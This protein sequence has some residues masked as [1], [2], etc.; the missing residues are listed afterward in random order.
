MVK[1]L[2]Y[3]ELQDL[4]SS[5]REHK[6]TYDNAFKSIGHFDRLQN[7]LLHEMEFDCQNYEDRAKVATKMSVMRKERRQ[8]KN[9]AELYRPLWEYLTTGNGKQMLRSLE[10]ISQQMSQISVLQGTRVYKKRCDN[11]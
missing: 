11:D 7:D 1:R 5:F 8:A 6:M 9:T 3:K 4:I 10:E 2:E